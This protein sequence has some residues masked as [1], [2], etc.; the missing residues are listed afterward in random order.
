[1][2]EDLQQEVR[3]A[4][5]RHR[6]RIELITASGTEDLY[7]GHMRDQSRL[8]FEHDVERLVQPDVV[9]SWDGHFEDA[10]AAQKELTGTLREELEEADAYESFVRGVGAALLS[11]ALGQE[12]GT[13]ETALETMSMLA[14]SGP[15]WQSGPL[16]FPGDPGRIRPPTPW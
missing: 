15:F 4:L 14:M 5:N 6:H 9:A 1:M 13:D 2:S 8:V 7:A 12:G 11:V 10:M 16:A 3:A